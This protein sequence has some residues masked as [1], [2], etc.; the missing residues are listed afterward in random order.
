MGYTYIVPKDL[1]KQ[2]DAFMESLRCGNKGIGPAGIARD[3]S[4]SFLMQCLVEPVNPIIVMMDPD[5]FYDY[6]MGVA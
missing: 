3:D 4:L 1:N 2:T 5:E 6:M